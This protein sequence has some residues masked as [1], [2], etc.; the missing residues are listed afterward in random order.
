M[1]NHQKRLIFGFAIAIL[2]L[3]ALFLQLTKTPLAITAYLFSL[4]TPIM[5]FGTLWLAASSTKNKYITNAAFPL[6]AYTYCVLNLFCGILLTALEQFGIWNIPVGWF[7]FI[8]IILLAFFAW[9]ILAMESGQ[10]V[11]EQVEKT[12]K[13]QTANWKLIRLEI[14]TIKETAPEV[15][16]KDIQSVIDA[17]R[18]ADPMSCPEIE[19]MDQ[20]IRLKLHLLERKLQEG[21][22][23]EIPAA[24]AEICSQIKIRNTRLK[25][26]K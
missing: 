23:E 19:E 9:R 8:Q 10:E 18:Y 20:M 16:L 7:C 17:V 4:L 13:S 24:C 14:E 2:V 5:F 26:F 3:T 6:Q 1:N 25:L 12:V 11:I 21:K 22:N 15:C